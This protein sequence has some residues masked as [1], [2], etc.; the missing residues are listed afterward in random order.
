MPNIELILARSLAAHLSVPAFLA[1]AS[2]RFVF[3]NEAAEIM[4]GKSMESG[5]DFGSEELLEMLDPRTDDG[6]AVTADEMPLPRA[7]QNGVPAHL[8][9]V[10]G[11]DGGKRYLATAIPLTDHDGLTFGALMFLFEDKR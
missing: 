11:K 4:I 2:S 9:A 10:S 3:V 8:H 5:I 7:I 1:D 6:R